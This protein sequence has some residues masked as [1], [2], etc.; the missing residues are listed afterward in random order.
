MQEK[1]EAALKKA[2]IK[3]MWQ[4]CL[5]NYLKQINAAAAAV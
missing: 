3:P 5:N 2:N 1:D 4:H